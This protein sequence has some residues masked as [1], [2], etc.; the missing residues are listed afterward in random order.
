VQ[1][2]VLDIE[3]GPSVQD[4][5]PFVLVLSV[6]DGFIE[7]TTQDLI[8]DAVTD[9]GQSCDVFTGRRCGVG[10]LEPTL[11]ERHRTT[12]P[13][14]RRRCRRGHL[15]R[16]SMTGCSVVVALITTFSVQTDG[17][18]WAQSA[19]VTNVSLKSAYQFLDLM[20]DQYATGTT[21]RLVQSFT[22]GVLGQENFTD[23]ETYDDALMIDAYLAEG[24]ADG[25]SRA[26]V[27]GDALL[28]VQAHDPTHDGRIR[29]AYAPAPL[30]SPRKVKITDRTSDVGNMA[31][32]GQS[33]VELYVATGGSSYLTGA[34]AI[35]NWIQS[36]CYDT[37]GAGGYTGGDAPH[38]YR[39]R[40]KSTEHNIDLYVL[41][42][43]LATETGNP[44][45][46]ARAAWARGFVAS[47]WDPSAGT[48]FVGTLNNGV[49]PNDSEHPEDVNSWSYLAFQDPVYSASLEWDVTNLAV[50]AVGFSGVSF[51]SGDRSGVWF[52]GTSHLADALELRDGPGDEAQADQY[53]ADVAYAQTNGPDNDGMGI[54]AASKNKLSDCDG[55]Y[56]YSSLHTGARAW[57]VLAA[58]QVNPLSLFAAS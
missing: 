51:C 10:S 58:Q 11:S 3:D 55:D 8:D 52:E 6:P 38:G 41:F 17:T 48:F 35:G 21:P 2:L 34:E 4:D 39:I 25:L 43:S 9:V 7:P 20:M 14:R 42:T 19:P 46:S 30:T 16:A 26:E 49:T 27:V 33:L 54:M 15:R 50:T 24:N 12:L 13:G 56:Y 29:E 32:V 45:W 22:G 18:A 1:P 23:S 5:H 53:L 47:M 31:W 28:Y 57:Y 36:N 40:W 37:R 44:V